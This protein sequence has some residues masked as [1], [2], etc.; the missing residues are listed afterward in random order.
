VSEP[1][2]NSTS[3]APAPTLPNVHFVPSRLVYVTG[4]KV[5][6]CV[7]TLANARGFIASTSQAQDLLWEVELLDRVHNLSLAEAQDD[8]RARDVLRREGLLK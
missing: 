1:T 7:F 3:C 5:G 2:S 4:P 8:P 6:A